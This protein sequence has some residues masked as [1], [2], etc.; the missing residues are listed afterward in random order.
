[1]IDDDQAE[2]RRLELAFALVDVVAVLQHADDRRVGARPADAVL[3]ELLDERRLGESRRRLR[4]LLL[5]AQHLE[6]QAIALGQRRQDAGHGL[7]IIY[8]SARRGPTR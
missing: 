4:E 2:R 3:L 7:D 5:G 6:L 8:D 1:Q